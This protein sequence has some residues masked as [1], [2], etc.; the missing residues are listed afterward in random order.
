MSRT[1]RRSAARR[2]QLR[3][4]LAARARLSAFSC[5]R[6]NARISCRIAGVSWCATSSTAGASTL[7]FARA[8]VGTFLELAVD[9]I[10]TRRRCER[11]EVAGQPEVRTSAISALIFRGEVLQQQTMGTK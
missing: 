3:R 10:Q 2:R 8:R 4:R 9:T 7:R 1:D 5:S 6:R 11:I